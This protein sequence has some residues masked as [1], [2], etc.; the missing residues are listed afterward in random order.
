[1]NFNI[2]LHNSAT[3][4][5]SGYYILFMY[6]RAFVCVCGEGDINI[7]MCVGHIVHKLLYA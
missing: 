6:V 7:I 1:M 5:Y 4:Y 2:I 3:D